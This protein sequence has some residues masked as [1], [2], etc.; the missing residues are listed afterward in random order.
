LAK[1]T[2][3][4]FWVDSQYGG[5]TARAFINRNTTGNQSTL[6]FT[7]GVAITNGT[8]WAGSVD[9]SMGMTN[10]ATNNFYIGYGDI[11]S[12]GNRAITI[13][14]SRNVGIGVTP[15]QSA[16]LTFADSLAQKILL[17]N[18]ANNYRIDL[19]A[20][21]NGGDALMK[22]VAG[23]TNAGEIGFY[24][25]TNLRMLINNVGNVGIGTSNP[26]SPLTINATAG[27]AQFN[28]TRSE[29]S[30]QG[31]SIQAGGGETTFNSY[32]GTNSVNGAYV[33][34]STK[35]STTT[36]RMRITSAGNVG[37]GIAAPTN[38]LHVAKTLP[39]E[40]IVNFTNPSSTGYGLYVAAASSTRYAFAIN[41]YANNPIM[42]VL[43]NGNVL[44]NRTSTFS[45]SGMLD[46]IGNASYNGIT[47][48]YGVSTN[49]YRRQYVYS[50]DNAM[51]F[52]NGTNQAYLTSGGVW[53]N[54]SD[55]SIKKDIK[56]IEYGLN[57]IMQLK[58]RWYK[59]KEDDV[60]Q[61]GFIAQ[62]VE[63]VIKEVVHTDNMNMKG[64]SYGNLTAVLVKAIQELQEQINELKN[65]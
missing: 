39:D 59:M 49:Q 7:T 53:T 3:T 52:Y 54:A 65:K 37:I 15:T 19:A 24:T 57:E 27:A 45:E 11:Y 17:N 9:W 25:T 26:A 10:D 4:E 48:G 42:R 12:A 6:M 55:I 29:Q 46:V 20:A 63:E 8:A 36:E 51:Y 14:S 43:G 44:I 61:I 58:P 31:F 56:D 30:N 62:E 16:A 22:F 23:S 21:V 18:N 5:G 40:A 35:G 1:G 41:D 64:L 28:I 50:G 13:T 60:E 34:N 32:D 2:N 38:L 33:F 47:Q